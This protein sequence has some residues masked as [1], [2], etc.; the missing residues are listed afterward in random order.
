MFVT[1]MSHR[2]RDLLPAR[3]AA[4]RTLARTG[5]RQGGRLLDKM[6]MKL[7]TF[8]DYGRR[9]LSCLALE[10]SR[11]DIALRAIGLGFILSMVTRHAPVILPAV[12]R[13]KL[14]FGC[15]FYLSRLT[16]HLSLALRLAKEPLDARLRQAGA[17][18]KAA[19]T[20]LSALTV[21][22]SALAWRVG[23]IAV[24]RVGQETS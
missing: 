7:T 6:A 15:P 12:A 9:A 16:L 23:Q 14:H 17:A 13:L 3:A 11:R 22:A 24:V 10:P 8:T 19:A 2:N 20:A 18:L 4:A 5:H 1:Y 21:A